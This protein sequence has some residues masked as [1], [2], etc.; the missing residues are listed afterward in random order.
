MIVGCV[1]RYESAKEVLAQTLVQT[2]GSRSGEQIKIRCYIR[3]KMNDRDVLHQG[4]Q[5]SH[6]MEGN[7]QEHE[8]TLNQ[9]GMQLVETSHQLFYT[10]TV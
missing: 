4:Q 5:G 8:Y 2:E 6:R 3:L 7:D 1:E 10:S 9:D